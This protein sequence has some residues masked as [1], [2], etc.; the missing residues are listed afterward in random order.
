MECIVLRLT[1]ALSRGLLGG[2][3]TYIIFRLFADREL[4]SINSNDLGEFAAGYVCGVQFRAF[5]RFERYSAK[6][7]RP[8]GV[9]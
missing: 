5:S 4:P 7:R 3:F 2:D 1:A 9:A 8:V 6:A